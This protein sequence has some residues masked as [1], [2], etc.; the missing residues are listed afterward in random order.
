MVCD[1]SSSV[2]MSSEEIVLFSLSVSAC[3]LSRLLSLRDDNV[4][5][6]LLS[7]RGDDE[8]CLGRKKYEMSC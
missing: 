7:L 6:R 5:P 4:S 3:T 8:P 1:C 2:V